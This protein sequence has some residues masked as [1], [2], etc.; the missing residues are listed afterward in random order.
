MYI[1]VCDIY[2]RMSTGIYVCILYLYMC[3]CVKMCIGMC[4]WFVGIIFQRGS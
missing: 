4:V 1:Y 2:V 3:V